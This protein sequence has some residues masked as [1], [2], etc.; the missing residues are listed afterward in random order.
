MSTDLQAIPLKTIDGT[1][2]TLGAFAGHPVLV[3]NVASKCG[4]T[5]QY[6]ALES[7][8]ETYAPRGLVVAGFPANNFGAQEPGTEAEIQAFCSTKYN[9]S[10]PMFS[11]I[12]VKGDDQHPLYKA[13]VAAQP[14]ATAPNG[15]D[16]KAKLEG[17]GIKIDNDTDVMW[18]FEKFLLDGTGAV[19]ARFSPD[20][21]P[22]APAVKAAIEK[23]LG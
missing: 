23:L 22:D 16:F 4:L 17:Y 7:L 9:V 15:S 8:Y 11:K 19:V 1:P 10:F 3:V 12:S 20:T 6:A 2:T 14:K 21:P 18:N 13:L 5:P